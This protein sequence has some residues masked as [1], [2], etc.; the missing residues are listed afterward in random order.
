MT[1]EGYLLK[2]SQ[3][4]RDGAMVDTIDRVRGVGAASLREFVPSGAVSVTVPTDIAAMSAVL[5]RWG[6]S[7]GKWLPVGGGQIPVNSAI[8]RHVWSGASS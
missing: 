5:L 8:S 3:G 7:C 6:S 2:V 1:D 4:D